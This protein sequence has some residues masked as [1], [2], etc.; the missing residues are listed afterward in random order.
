ML[1][2]ISLCT[3]ENFLVVMDENRTIEGSNFAYTF[4]EYLKF[5]SS[6]NAKIL[7]SLGNSL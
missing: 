5:L 3:Q 4:I 6:G 1:K 7:S 2:Q